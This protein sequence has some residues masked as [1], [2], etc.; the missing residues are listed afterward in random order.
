MNAF[1]EAAWLLLLEG[2]RTG[3]RGDAPVQ[4]QIPSDPGIQLDD[5][6]QLCV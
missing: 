5:T 1:I 6:H 4:V 3:R 2:E